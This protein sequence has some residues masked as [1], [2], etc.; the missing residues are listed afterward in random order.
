MASSTRG[1]CGKRIGRPRGRPKPN[2]R[3]ALCYRKCAPPP[4]KW[5]P[6]NPPIWP[7]PKPPKWP[8]PKPPIWP[9]L[10][11][12]KASEVAAAEAARMA[13]ISAGEVARTAVE[14]VAEAI[15]VTM[16]IEAGVVAVAKAAIIWRVVAA[17]A[18]VAV[19][20]SAIWP[21]IIVITGIRVASGKSAEDAADDAGRRGGAG[22]VAIAVG[23]TMRV[24]TGVMADV[25]M[26]GEPP[27][28]VRRPR[29]DRMGRVMNRGRRACG[30]QRGQG[31]ESD[32]A[33]RDG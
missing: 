16:T 10:T 21:V 6:P 28:N 23:V 14:A 27:V 26:G 1:R 17:P 24:A 9:K 18:V 19:V 22:I 3:Q 12:A 13:E 2:V 20:A 5:P 8:P 25:V 30:G 32:Y 7:P 15:A 29:V 33:E 11:A 4:P 31:R